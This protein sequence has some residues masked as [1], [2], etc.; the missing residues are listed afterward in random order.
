MQYKMNATTMT[1]KSYVV[2]ASYAN[3]W[4]NFPKKVSFEV[5]L[6]SEPPIT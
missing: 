6:N 5:E 4:E 2:R 3:Y 1:L